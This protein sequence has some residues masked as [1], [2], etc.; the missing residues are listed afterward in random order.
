MT[1]NDKQK[2]LCNNHNFDFSGLS[3]VFLNCTLKPSGS[4]SHTQALIKVSQA[5]MEANE[6]STEVLRA[7]DFDLPPGVYPD[8]TDHGFKS[9]QWPELC[10][11]IMEPNCGLFLFSATRR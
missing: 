1:L 6:I 11:K 2:A 10:A 4:L 8:M 3:A 9:D 5:I 7:V